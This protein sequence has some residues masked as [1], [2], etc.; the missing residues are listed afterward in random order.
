MILKEIEKIGQN[1]RVPYQRR[2]P[3]NTAKDYY[4]IHR[5]TGDKTQ[6]IMI[7]YGFVDSTGDDSEQLK[8]DYLKYAE[9][10]VKAVMEYIGKTYTPPTTMNA[11]MYTVKSGDNLY[12]IA[13]S[14]N[15]TVAELM[16]YNNL[17]SNLLQVGQVLRIPQNNMIDNTYIVKSGDSLWNIARK[18]N[19]TVDE[20]KKKNNLTS[21]L[22]KIGQV[23]KI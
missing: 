7:L 16:K 22:L 14:Y 10:V 23:L 17:T 9:A 5:D 12:K 8:K 20:L 2:L 21:N 13:D 11:N 1:T 3:S 6:P 18:F 15:T 19:V 4:F